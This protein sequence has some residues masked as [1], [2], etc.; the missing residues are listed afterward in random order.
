MD[1]LVNAFHE[2]DSYD[3]KLK[4]LSISPYSH[5]KTMNIFQATDYMVKKSRQLKLQYGIIPEIPIM[6]KGKVIT[7]EVKNWVKIFFERD[8]ISRICP[9]KKD[10]ISIRNIETG[11]KELI[12]KRLILMNLKEAYAIYKNTPDAPDIGFSSFCSIRPKFCILAGASGT[13]TVCVCT[14]HQNVKL[15][16]SAIGLYSIDYKMLMSKFA[17]SLTN[18]K[19]MLHLCSECPGENGIKSYLE[20]LEILKEMDVLKYKQWVSVDRC[21]LI[22]QTETVE[23]YISS[24]SGKISKLTRHHYISKAQSSF[25]RRLKENLLANEV[26]IL[27]D[28]AENYSFLI[29]DEVQG[30]H[31]ENSQCTVHPFVI[32]RT[33]ICDGEEKVVPQSFCFISPDTKHSTAMVYTFLCS[34]IPHIKSFLPN[35]TKIYYFSDGCAGQY[36]N[37]YNFTNIYYHKK[38]FGVACEWHF[39]ATSHGK[40]PCDGIGGV[41]KRATT[42]ASLQ[43]PYKD[44]ILTPQEMFRFCENNLKEIKFFFITNG[45][46]KEKEEFLRNRFEQ[47]QTIKGTQRLHKYIPSGSGKIIVYETSD[48]D[49][50][51]ERQVLKSSISNETINFPNPKCGDYVICHYNDQDWIG[52]IQSF[53]AE[54]DDFRIQFL[55]PSGK[56]KYYFYP[57]VEDACNIAADNII[58]VLSI[59][60]LNAG[61]KRI[62]YSFPKEEVKDMS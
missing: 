34:L 47:A 25:L 60:S 19:C 59:P 36:K 45:Q 29:Q 27:M 7:K 18:R 24:L 46:V 3:R 42:R 49:E 17:C 6:S 58:K 20:H 54:F 43:R 35:I 13:H 10:C 48:S 51:D 22:D 21:S 31:W 61:T 44:Q 2:T 4:I 55:H 28:F 11:E 53:D 37:K 14:Y 39:F 56:S 12:Q 9:G 50:G 5:R 40:S 23:E 33:A 30:Y 26:I 38:D 41:V 32:Y 16:V 57:A 52:F 62:Q 15:Q 8:D 1:E